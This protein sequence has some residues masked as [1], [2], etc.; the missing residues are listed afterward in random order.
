MRLIAAGSRMKAEGLKR[1]FASDKNTLVL[2]IMDRNCVDHIKSAQFEEVFYLI[3]D[4]RRGI[5]LNATSVVKPS[6]AT[7]ERL[8]LDTIMVLIK[9]HLRLGLMLEIEI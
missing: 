3:H 8:W 2:N 9:A 7:E 6:N 1:Q 4:I 5:E